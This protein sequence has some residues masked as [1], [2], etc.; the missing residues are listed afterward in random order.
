MFVPP[1]SGRFVDYGWQMTMVGDRRLITEVDP[2]SDAAARGLAPGDRVLLLNG[3]TPSRA[4]AWSM[5]YYYRYIRPQ[6]RQRMRC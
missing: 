2:G 5:N 1:T 4:N 3:V 6:V